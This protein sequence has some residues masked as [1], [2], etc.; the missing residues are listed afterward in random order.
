[1]NIRTHDKKARLTGAVRTAFVA[2]GTAAVA[3]LGAGAAQ[4]GAAGAAA[5]GLPTPPTSGPLHV[6]ANIPL[7]VKSPVA[8]LTNPFAEAPNGAVFFGNGS[9]VEVVES[10]GAPT[11]A[12]HTSGTVI[13][14]G[15][16]ATDLYVLVGSTVTDYSRSTGHAVESWKLPSSLGKPTYGGIFARSGVVWIWTDDQ[17]DT[18]GFEYADVTAL[19]AGSK[20][21]V[22]DTTAYPRSLDSDSNGFIY[23]VDEAGRL[24]RG[25]ANGIRVMSPDP[26]SPPIAFAISSGRLVINTYAQNKPLW[27]T[28]YLTSL[29]RIQTHFMSNLF[30]ETYANTGAGLLGWITPDGPA[31]TYQV[32]RLA[33]TTGALS[34]SVAVGGVEQILEGY[35]PALVTNT[36]GTLHL[37]R[38]D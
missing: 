2:A 29:T 30:G 1:M 11:V 21:R 4:V 12:E 24:V 23:Y 9:E 38:I 35:Y 33:L 25:N 31:I 8:G 17:T 36:T 6:I 18:S 3:A 32:G 15:A 20:V 16:S 13:A 5:P 34:D 27:S 7:G 19:T 28:W 26:M 22:I 37:V 10:T 14:L